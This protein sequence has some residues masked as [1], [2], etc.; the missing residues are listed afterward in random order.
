MAPELPWD[1]KLTQVPCITKALLSYPNV[2]IALF[3]VAVRAHQA[4]SHRCRCDL[5]QADII[6]EINDGQVSKGLKFA[7]N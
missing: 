6:S 4:H 5:H 1:L 2:F 7:N 3:R